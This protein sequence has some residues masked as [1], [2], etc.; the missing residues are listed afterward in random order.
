MYVH[1]KCTFYIKIE[2]IE[3]FVISKTFDLLYKLYI[4]MCL[5]RILAYQNFDYI[6]TIFHHLKRGIFTDKSKMN[7]DIIL[8]K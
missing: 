1:R 5:Y 3:I 8:V 7:V 2:G 6:E 4:L